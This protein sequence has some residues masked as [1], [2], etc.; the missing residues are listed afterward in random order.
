[1]L[2]VSALVSLRL[3]HILYAPPGHSLES[4]IKLVVSGRSRSELKWARWGGGR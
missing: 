2:G 3:M 4:L 1:M